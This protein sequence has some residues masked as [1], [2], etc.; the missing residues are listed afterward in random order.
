M[1]IW[2]TTTINLTGDFAYDSRIKG[3]FQAIFQDLFLIIFV[4][5]FLNVKCIEYFILLK[6][7]TMSSNSKFI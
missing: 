2:C 4:R 1:D 7:C 6:I 5:A 3:L